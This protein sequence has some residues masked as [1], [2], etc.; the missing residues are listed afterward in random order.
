VVDDARGPDEKVQ[1]Q[2]P[3]V[4]SAFLCAAVLLVTL[5]SRAQQ[6][7]S[8][9]AAE[10]R[11]A[12]IRAEDGTARLADTVDWRT[13]RPVP[14]VRVVPPSR[15]L[16]GENG[17]PTVPINA[18]TIDVSQVDP[19][20]Y[21]ALGAK[22]PEGRRP[23]IDGRMNDDVWQLAPAFG[24]FIQTEP[25]VGNPATQ[26]TE[27]RILYDNRSLFFGF[28]MWDQ[29]SRGIRA[30]E[31]K[32]DALLRKG[33][34]IKVVFDPF[35][36]RRN[37]FYFSTN[38]LGAYKDGTGAD[39]GRIQSFEWN[40]NWLVGATRD[41]RGWYAEI[42]VPLSQIRY[43]ES[44]GEAVWGLQ[45]CR[46]LIRR[47]E[48]TCWT[49]YPREYGPPGIWR[50][51]SGGFLHLTTDLPSRRRLEITPYVAPTIVRNYAAATPTD[52]ETGYGVDV[53]AGITPT[54]TADVTYKTDFGQVEADQEIVNLSRFSQFF[55]EN[56]QF[57]TEA[58][59]IFDYGQGAGLV[60]E[61]TQVLQLF[62][63]R[64][65]GLD[66]LGR[67]IP[68]LGGSRVTGRVRDYQ[69]GL[70]NIQT[71]RRRFSDNNGD[72]KTVPTANYSVARVK[73]S[74]L[75]RSSIGAMFTNREDGDGATSYNRVAGVD[76]GLQFGNNV[77]VAGLLAKSFSP[78]GSGN[79]MAGVIDVDY[80]TDRFYG[81]AMY[82]DIAERF[83]AEMGFITRTDIR[84]PSVVA[85]WTPWPRR[86]GVKRL[87]INGSVD[88]FHNHR[89]ATESRIDSVNVNLTRDDNAAFTASVT[90]EFDRLVVP[91][92]IG[93]L[94]VAPAG[95]TWTTQTVGYQT[96]QSRRM[97]G[98]GTLATGGY[99]GG[100]RTAASGN[101]A[102]LP[103]ETL[104][105]EVNYTRN[106]IVLPEAPTYTTNTVN[107]RVSHSFTR[108]LFV[109][110][111]IQ[112]NDA[113]R[114]ANLNLLLWYR[115]KMGSDFYIVY[116]QGWDTDL[117][118]PRKVDTRDRSLQ[119]KLT[120]WFA[121]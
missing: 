101:V 72:E 70:M 32:R 20:T 110:S 75:Q 114:F 94:T 74:I 8:G 117:P 73:K 63:S 91:F 106:R 28:W 50:I 14:A 102:F 120:Y 71:E 65:I 59:T 115:Y 25:D 64:R 16:T 17:A 11:V 107:A 26:P 5:D 81:S 2:G 58:A 48:N 3:V 37:V 83:N 113:R 53:R 77:A 105:V 97:Y 60:G 6:P 79:D 51:A 29:D 36:D 116:N 24:N 35:N 42:E 85:G 57:F 27:F 111:F 21:H 33:D 62:Y 49:P 78:G 67:P 68:L 41:D 46:V 121:R 108:D 89:G 15:E 86:Y 54:L 40:A 22:L 18:E 95:Y 23:R 52:V 100:D 13:V 92:A 31:L 112:Y 10:A 119:I 66:A 80:R 43:H 19:L 30:S 88:H 84:N 55:P 98:G 56:R 103:L 109:K 82:R 38:P 4:R 44:V 99:Y 9:A 45:V 1:D 69:I 7:Q 47:N 118:G 39:N 96:D 90:R 93:P 12:G 76:L 87:D 61:S 104:L 34:Q